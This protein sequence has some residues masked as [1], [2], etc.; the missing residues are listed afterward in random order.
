MINNSLE[1]IIQK[2]IV[3]Y[4]HCHDHTAEDQYGSK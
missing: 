1:G 2:L 4:I 3:L